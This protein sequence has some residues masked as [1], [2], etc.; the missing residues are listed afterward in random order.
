MRAA[1]S[2]H[3]RRRRRFRFLPRIRSTTPPDAG[4]LAERQAVHLGHGAGLRVG[5]IGVMTAQA[6]R[7]DDR[8]QH[9]R[10]ALGAAGRDDRRR[11]EAAARDGASMVVVTSHAG[12]RCTA[13]T[14]P[15]DLSS[16]QPNEEIMQVARALPAGLVDVIVAGHAHSGMA[17]QV[18]GVSI[19]E[20]VHGRASVWTSRS[21]RGLV[22][23]RR[24]IGGVSLRRATVCARRSRDNAVRPGGS[25]QR[26]GPCGI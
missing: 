2:K 9:R 6:L 18:A 24:I 8:D 20:V 16:V 5:I 3:A 4:R 15:T 26:P 7:G 25:E 1:R 10:P 19:I 12:G 22:P 11:G 21:R 17:H 23:A 13:F 14:T